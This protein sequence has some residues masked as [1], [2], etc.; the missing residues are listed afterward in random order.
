MFVR[1]DVFT[2]VGNFDT[3]ISQYGE[4]LDMWFRIALLYPQIGYANRVGAIYWTRKGS[5]MDTNP[6]DVGHHLMRIQKAEGHA[7][8][9]GGTS[10]QKSEPVVL[11]WVWNQ[12]KFAAVQ[13]NKKALEH[14]SKFYG[15]R[16]PMRH[17]LVLDITRY[18]PS[19]SLWGAA[20]KLMTRRSRS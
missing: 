13:G 10:L 20:R 2:R 4:D 5:L 15:R 6:R 16:L 9:A 17:R 3:S 8:L 19:R 1:R 7:I 11:A 12:I 14:I 18:F